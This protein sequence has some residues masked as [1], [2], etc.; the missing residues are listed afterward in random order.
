MQWHWN[1]WESEISTLILAQRDTCTQ[2]IQAHTHKSEIDLSIFIDDTFDL[3]FPFGSACSK[4]K[5][6]CI[7]KEMRKL[8]VSNVC[9][10]LHI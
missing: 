9:K 5:C 1:G 7:S 2:Q 8:S 10:I 4:C 6:D 3:N